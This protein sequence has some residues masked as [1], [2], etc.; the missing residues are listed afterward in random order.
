MVKQCFLGFH[1][2]CEQRAKLIFQLC[3]HL[4]SVIR[5][6]ISFHVLNLA[7]YTF[8]FYTDAAFIVTYQSNDCA[9]LNVLTE[10]VTASY[11]YRNRSSL[12]S[13]RRCL[14][15]SEGPPYLQCVTEPPSASLC[16]VEDQSDAGRAQAACWIRLPDHWESWNKLKLFY[17]NELQISDGS[18]DFGPV[19]QYSRRRCAVILLQK[20][21]DLAWAQWNK[22]L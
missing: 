3:V 7:F 15:S 20:N 6:Y 12:F 16:L 5:L 13:P 19:H 8:S 9:H 2:S 14:S 11:R 1:V 18:K 21:E 10:T 4:G 22:R 17:F